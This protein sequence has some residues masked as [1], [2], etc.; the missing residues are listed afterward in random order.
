[1]DHLADLH[2]FDI[3]AALVTDEIKHMHQEMT[4]NTGNDISSIPDELLKDQAERRVKLGLIVGEIIRQ[5]DIKKDPI[6]VD[7]KLKE[8]ASTYEDPNALI[9]YYRNNQ[10]AMQT[11]EAAVMEDAIIDWALEQVTVEEKVSNFDS[12][13]NRNAQ[14]IKSSDNVKQPE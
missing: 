5:N 2:E 11:I 10:Q 13:M 4:Q 14:D 8:L 1:M 3:P 7:T 6:K 9:D 12:V